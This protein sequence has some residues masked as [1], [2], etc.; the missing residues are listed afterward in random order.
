MEKVM[1]KALAFMA[2][3]C[4][5]PFLSASAQ[6]AWYD[7]FYQYRIPVVM[8]SPQAGW[9]EIPIDQD[10]ITASI[11]A[12]EQL[13]YDS[14]WLAYNHLKVIEL[15]EQGNVIGENP[16][17]GFYVIPVSDEL[18]TEEITG[19]EQTV[20]IP[21]EK[22]AFYLAT[23]VS[24]DGGASPFLVY[25][26]IFPIGTDLRKQAYMSSY[27]AALLPLAETEHERL[28]MSDGQPMEVRLNTRHVPNVTS[29]SVR[30]VE[31]KFL[32]N[33]DKAGT[34]RWMLYYQPQSGHF[35]KIPQLRK[36]EVPGSVARVARLGNAQKYTDKTQY[37]LVDNADMAVWFA[38]TIVKITPESAVPAHAK[39]AAQI[40]AAK[41]EA[42][43]FQL[44][45][46]PKSGFKFQAIKASDLTNGDSK[47]SAANV[48]FKALDYVNIQTP[49]YITPVKFQGP[50]ADPLV[51]VSPKQASVMTGNLGFWVTVSVPSDVAA[52]T[53]RG[54]ITLECGG[55]DDIEVPIALEVYDFELPEFASLQSSLGLQYLSKRLS[56]GRLN[57]LDYHG[58]STREGLHKLFREYC[59]VMAEN[60][61]YPKTV[62]MYSEIGMKWSPP[63][64]GYN[65]NGTDNF[66]ML[67]DWDF[68]KF[69]ED[70]RYYID[71]L[72]VNSVCLTHNNPT[73]SNMFKH[74]PGEPVDE[75]LSPPH[76]TMAWQYFRDHTYVVWDKQPGDAYYDET[77]EVTVE[78]F[79]RLLLDFYRAIAT[80]LE[81]NGWLD[82]FYIQIDETDNDKRIL[83]F[84]RLLRSDPLT[85]KIK[86]VGCMQGL[87]Y[88]HHKDH[89]DDETYSYNGLLTYMPQ[90]D[91]NYQRWE[92][93]FW[94]DYD[95]PEGREWLWNYAVTGTR[96]TVD[97]PGVNNRMI[98]L[99]LFNRGASGF[100]DWEIA[101]WD[102]GY[103]TGERKEPWQ[104]VWSVEGNGV[105]TYF[106]P[107]RKL[108]LADEPDYTITPSLRVA[109]FRESADDYEY[110]IILERR[111]K[112]AKA[113]G[114]DTT[115]AEAALA[116]LDRFFTSMVSWSQNDE[117]FVQMRNE[118]ASQI[119][120]LG[121]HINDASVK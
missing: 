9:I 71:E 52:G 77:I 73:V 39:A 54:V 99:D 59:K 105:L 11:N 90:D 85:A 18:F 46:T 20:H 45:L 22:G 40:S 83:H 26:Q 34:K 47:I 24:S 29:V 42:Q 38:D 3:I 107:P 91:E 75:V 65:V 87:N 66:F 100:L 95:L 16:D 119:V 10:A 43:S 112:A 92:D 1:H 37:R 50:I 48:D 17:A 96:M 60:K 25:D 78:Q 118:I 116:E 7:T 115:E 110:A 93:Y 108:G 89:P 80:N 6:D 76:V 2:A 103:Y 21:T 53:Y 55:A 49:S 44:M 15:D 8:D 70:M 69:N 101:L 74:L 51:A 35:L 31:I 98:G 121:Q 88:L 61:F 33:L 106:Y 32:A 102:G 113:Q 104:D 86:I 79:D 58:I 84:L 97:V 63:P 57:M 30:K 5:T 81:N 23:Y 41:N 82:K 109:T 28:M 64:Q 120:S 68:S 94:T 67:Y 13:R 12:C 62:A 111:I 56:A 36:K 72:K 114:I 19:E 4:L 14:R 117:R 27:E